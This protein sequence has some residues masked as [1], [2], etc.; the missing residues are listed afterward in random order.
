[1]VFT[2]G[3]I[4]YP[5]RDKEAATRR[6]KAIGIKLRGRRLS[7]EHREKLSLVKLNKPR[8]GYKMVNGYKYLFLPEHPFKRHGK[9]YAEHR[10]SIEGYLRKTDP[11]NIAL[12]EVEG[13][14][15][16]RRDWVV[17][18]IDRNKLNNDPMNLLPSPRKKHHGWI[19]TCPHCSRAF[20]Y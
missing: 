10:Y 7:N 1:M 8:I 19:V 12:V 13:I 11:N 2:K 16:L 15:Y 9:Y 17:H 18:H 3:H 6:A 4:Y 14:K 5:P 20:N